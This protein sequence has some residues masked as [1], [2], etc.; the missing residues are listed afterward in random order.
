VSLDELL[1]N[2][3]DTDWSEDEQDVDG[4]VN[5]DEDEDDCDIDTWMSRLENA[6]ADA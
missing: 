2:W 4:V 6:D 1:D 3:D 5:T